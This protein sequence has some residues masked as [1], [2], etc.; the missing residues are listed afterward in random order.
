MTLSVFPDLEDFLQPF[1]RGLEG[2][3]CITRAF[4]SDASEDDNKG[5]SLSHNYYARVIDGN[6]DLSEICEDIDQHAEYLD[7]EWYFT[8]AVFSRPRRRLEDFKASNALWLD[9]DMKAEWQ[10]F[11]PLPTFVVQSR[12]GPEELP[13]RCQ[14]FWILD[15]PITDQFKLRHLNRTAFN[16]FNCDDESCVTPQHL[17]KLPFGR[18]LKLAARLEDG[19]YWAPKLLVGSAEVW[20]AAEFQAM[21]EPPENSS[22]IRT[23]TV[24]VPDTLPDIQDKNWKEWL[25]ELSNYIPQGLQNRIKVSPPPG[26]IT[27]SENLYGIIASLLDFLTPDNI[28]RVVCGSPNDKFT[29]KHGSVRG[30]V[31]L[32]S[33]IHRIYDKTVSGKPESDLILPDE[34]WEARAFLKTIR[35]TAHSRCTSADTVLACTLARLSGMLDYRT[36]LDTGL[37][38]SPANMF[39]ILLGATGVGKGASMKASEDILKVPMSLTL[40]KGGFVD[41]SGVGSGEGIAECYMGMA[42]ETNDEG[43]KE[44]VRKQIRHNA[45]LTADEGKAFATQAARKGSTL[46]PTVC[47]AWSG[48]TLGQMNATSERTRHVPGNSYSLGLAI[49][50]QESTVLPILDEVDTGLPQRFLWLHCLDPNI[51]EEPI[52]EPMLPLGGV[53]TK[54][55]NQTITFAETIRQELWTVRRQRSA[56]TIETPVQRSQEPLMLCKIAGLL[57]LLDGRSHVDTDDWGLAKTVWETSVRVMDSALGYHKKVRAQKTYETQQTAVQLETVKEVARGV[58]MDTMERIA[59]LLAEEV[60]SGERVTRGALRSK[61]NSRDRLLFDQAADQAIVMGWLQVDEIGI[62]TKGTVNP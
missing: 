28:F 49:G 19:S 10:S 3:I 12:P 50:F 34:F 26:E 24:V 43:K 51:P 25:S 7:W 59:R 15:E 33:D 39:T 56:G 17:M 4:R 40:S 45:F 8:P 27:R 1:T 54:A 5:W 29:A 22:L 20:S 35:K 6:A 44:T 41:G 48:S 32:W 11:D 37:G 38:R 18:N 52:D 58:A 13:D 16:Y 42:V 55:P 23:G 61:L 21:P 47:S 31:Y 2:Y 9:F 46:V 14:C 30:P 62:Y 36:L 60:H 57:A 53:L